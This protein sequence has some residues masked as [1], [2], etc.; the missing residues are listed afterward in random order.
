MSEHEQVN[1]L[2]E[3]EVAMRN[4]R[5][6]TEEKA[7]MMSVFEEHRAELIAERAQLLEILPDAV[8]FEDLTARLKDLVPD[9]VALLNIIQPKAGIETDDFG[10]W[11]AGLTDFLIMENPN[12]Y[13]K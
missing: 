2:P 12:K 10:W 7:E 5:F 4:R 1:Y 9:V 8:S 3:E 6:T 11:K 13:T